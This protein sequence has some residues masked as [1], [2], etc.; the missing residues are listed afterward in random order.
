M[1]ETNGKTK[2]IIR[3]KQNKQNNYRQFL[4]LNR[5]TIEKINFE[6]KGNMLGL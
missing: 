1:T 2:N 3:I 5:T 4:V 6:K